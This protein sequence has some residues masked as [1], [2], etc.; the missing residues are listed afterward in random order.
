VIDPEILRTTL[1]DV[2]AM[3]DT[4]PRRFYEL[5][6]ERHPEVKPLFVRSTPG[7]LRKMFAQKLCALVDHVSDAAWLDRELGKLSAAHE[8]YGVTLAMYPWVG[9]ALIDTLRE[10]LGPAFTPSVE[11]NWREAYALMTAVITRAHVA[12]GGDR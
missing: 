3:D 12:E 11:R 7:A 10:A 6:F 8:R 1:E 9:D 2:L 4:F 5:L